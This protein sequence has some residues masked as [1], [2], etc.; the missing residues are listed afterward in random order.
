MSYE[1]ISCPD[2]ATLARE[3]A[4]R[5]LEK[6]A[7]SNKSNVYTVAL[8]GGRIAKTFFIEIV[9]QSLAQ[10]I[11]FAGVHFFW[12]DERCVPP[13]DPESNY[14][15]ARQLLLA[16]LKIPQSQIHRLQ[17]E[18]PEPVALCEAV[19]DIIE[20]AGLIEGQPRLD[21]VILG[22]GE[23]GHVASLFP[24]EPEA[25]MASPDIYRVVTAVKPPPKRITLGYGAIARS[26]ETWVMVSGTG[27]ER[28][29]GQ[30]LSETGG[31]PLARV[32]KMRKETLIFS[33]VKP[34]FV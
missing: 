30:S 10:P 27:K 16:P 11:S 29:L 31:T 28:A 15:V 7:A 22:M 6:L 33:D 14:A 34:E 19:K 1:L 4:K 5:W 9:R 3:V 32:L 12:A 8:S 23:D 21:L 20:V 2:D 18:K 13:T 17:G 24:G 26:V 25:V